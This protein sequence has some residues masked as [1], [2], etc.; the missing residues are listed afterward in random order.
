M[1]ARA[2]TWGSGTRA[3]ASGWNSPDSR[4]RA[5]SGQAAHPPDWAPR[6]GCAELGMGVQSLLTSDHTEAK[7]VGVSDAGLV[8]HLLEQLPPGGLHLP[9]SRGG[10]RCSRY[11]GPQSGGCGGWGHRAGAGWAGAWLRLR[12]RSQCSASMVT[13]FTADQVAPNSAGSL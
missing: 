13:A 4:S 8:A 2:S 7:E 5:D 10:S 1:T 12:P 11:C 6:G 9:K 3:G